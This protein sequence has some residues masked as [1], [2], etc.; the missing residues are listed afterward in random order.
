[1]PVQ[2]NIRDIRITRINYLFHP[3]RISQASTTNDALV[4]DSTEQDLQVHFSFKTEQ[5]VESGEQYLLKAYQGVDLSGNT[6][7]PFSLMVEV[8]AIFVLDSLPPPEE[9]LRL[10]HVTCNAV[11]FPYLREAVSEITRRGGQTPVYL[12]PMNFLEMYRDGVFRRNTGS[13]E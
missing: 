3:E 10:Q 12:Q 1:M 2:F 4:S 7:I 11:L 9:L 5:P 13:E 6:E 8:G